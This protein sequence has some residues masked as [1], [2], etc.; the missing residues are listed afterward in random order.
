M[1][2][3]P[4]SIAVDLMLMVAIFQPPQTSSVV[5]SGCLRGAGDNLYV[6]VVMIICVA[7]IRPVLS[8]V[9]VNVF[10][11]GIIGAWGASLIDMSLRFTLAYRRFSGSKWQNIKV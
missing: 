6:A 3:L 11:L 9:A 5:I 4:F 8:L 2:A 1:N 10:G 7:V